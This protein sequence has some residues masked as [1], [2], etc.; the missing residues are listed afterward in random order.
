[1]RLLLSI[2]AALVLL[3][4]HFASAQAGG[5]PTAARS[6]FIEGPGLAPDGSTLIETLSTWERSGT[7]V[8]NGYEAIAR[9]GV[10]ERFELR[11][12]MP[13]YIQTDRSS[14]WS[15]PYLGAKW[16]LAR[17][18][19]WELS[20]TGEGTLS[21]G[22]STFGAGEP[23]ATAI[24]S[25][26]RALDGQWYLGAEMIGT[27]ATRSGALTVAPTAFVTRGLSDRVISFAEL[28][29]D[30]LESGSG[31][32]LVRGG[33]SLLATPTVQLDVH[34]GAGLSDRVP[35]VLIGLGLNA[36]LGRS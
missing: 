1:M 15:D 26:A 33:L 29:F 22:S 10:S 32:S 9:W 14:G 36:R 13:D 27:W 28:A 6:T 34:G 21:M 12:G 18:A 8:A 4:P 35:D 23:E 2:Q 5:D 31:A 7:S 25:A 30:P 11:F 24:V 17:P 16:A 20:V 3:L 19:G